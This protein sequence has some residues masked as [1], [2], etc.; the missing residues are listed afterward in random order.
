MSSSARK[1]AT[2]PRDH[3]PNSVIFP[4]CIRSIVLQFLIVSFETLY[5][6]LG[7]CKITSLKDKYFKQMLQYNLVINAIQENKCLRT[8]YE[9][10]RKSLGCD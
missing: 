10:S 8:L 2:R 9:E 5:E 3:T 6:V 7:A 4:A 1:M